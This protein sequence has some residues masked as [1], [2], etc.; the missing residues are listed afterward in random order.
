M[1]FGEVRH[2]P[3]A[4]S[5]QCHFPP[6][7]TFQPSVGLG[8]NDAT[9]MSEKPEQD[10]ID[11][12]IVDF[13]LDDSFSMAAQ[14]GADWMINDQWLVNFDLRWIDIDAD[15]EGTVD[16]GVSPPATAGLGSVKI[17]PW[18]VAI[19]VGYRF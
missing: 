9:F 5:V 11:A 13:S 3:P 10:V 16:N 15:L 1:P 2:L 19:N 12:G 14:V 17:D 4:F 6:Y 7:A 8:V 18:V